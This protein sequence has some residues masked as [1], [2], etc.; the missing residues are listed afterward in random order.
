MSSNSS[1][2]PLP[3]LPN[4]SYF[5]TI[6]LDRTNC[7]LWQAQILPL[8]RSRNL[9]SFVE[10]T[11]K[12]PRAFLKDADGN[13]TDDVNPDFEAWI[14]QDT[15]VMSW[16]NSLVHLTI[17]F[18][19]GSPV[20]DS[21]IV[22]IVLKNVSPAYKSNVAPAQAQDEAISYSA[23]EALLLGAEMRQKMHSGFG[24]DNAPTAFAAVRNGSRAPGG[25]RGRGSSSSFRGRSSPDGGRGP[26]ASRSRNPVNPP[27]GSQ[28]HPNNG[29]SPSH[30]NGRIQCRI[31]NRH[32]HSAINCYN[33]LNM[34]CEW[35]V[36]APRLQAFAAAGPPISP[37]APAIQN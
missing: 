15:M 10:G 26:S 18:L 1:P 35:K 34:S 23:L 25:F 37:S 17:L 32:G 21:D 2:I 31:C 8:L 30:C 36:P 4:A 16:V 22:V 28:S 11:S 24:N 6:K 33:C 7:P 14:Q 3:V 20:T 19:S 13:L 29:H 27:R 12:C 5:I 9:V